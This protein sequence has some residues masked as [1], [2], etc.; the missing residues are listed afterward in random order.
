MAYETV[1]KYPAVVT[2]IEKSGPVVDKV[3]L[4]R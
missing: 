2:L 3:G 4:V 1:L